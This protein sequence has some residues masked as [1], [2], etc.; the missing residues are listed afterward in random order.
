MRIIAAPAEH[1]PEFTIDAVVL[2]DDT[3]LVLGSEPLPRQT[4][5]SP[6]HLLDRASAAQPATPGTVVV[7]GGTP[8]RLHAVVH[9]LSLNPSWREAWIAAALA[10]VFQ[11]VEFRRLR[12]VSLPPLGSLHGTLS[13]G[14]FARL[15]AAALQR[16]PPPH[17]DAVW[18][19][20]P[21]EKSS[22]ELA[23]LREFGLIIRP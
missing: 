13:L 5:E 6:R 4:R 7:R 17:L 18:L 16:Q 2:E 14:S 1:A 9:D 20:T 3:Y 11:E 23:A 8:L 15:L 10:A 21:A 12:A 22:D 19:V